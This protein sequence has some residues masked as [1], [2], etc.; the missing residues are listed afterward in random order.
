MRKLTKILA[1]ILMAMAFI[2]PLP[3]VDACHD[4]DHA[5]VSENCPCECCT[6]PSYECSESTIVTIQPD[7]RHTWIAESLCIEILLVPDIFRPPALA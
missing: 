2:V 7:I 3:P 1:I 6:A 5:D 4:G